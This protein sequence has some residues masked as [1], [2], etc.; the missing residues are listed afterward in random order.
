M[1]QPP[2]AALCKDNS[3]VQK[4]ESVQVIALKM[5]HHSL[6]P[7]LIA[8]LGVTGAQLRVP[9]CNRE[10]GV[11]GHRCFSF[12]APCSLPEY[13]LLKAHCK[14]PGRASCL[15]HGS[16]NMAFSRTC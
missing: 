7:S 8:I 12:G 9:I 15:S 13:T 4:S 14:K 1:I 6:H 5:A 3:S 16:L 2:S 10:Q 11:M